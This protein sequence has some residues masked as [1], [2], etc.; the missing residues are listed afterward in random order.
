MRTI[1]LGRTGE[2][3]SQLALGCMLMGTMTDEDTATAVLDHYLESGGSFLDTANGYMWW[4]APGS[5]GGESESLIGRW[6]QRR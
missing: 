4:S 6:L 2:R 3:V 1:E 5:L